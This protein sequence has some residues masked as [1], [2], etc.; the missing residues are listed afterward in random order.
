MKKFSL[1]TLCMMF[2]SAMYAQPRNTQHPRGYDQGHVTNEMHQNSAYNTPA[3]Y[4]VKGSWDAYVTGSFIYWQ[5]ME[6]GFEL[7]FIDINPHPS[8]IGF[9]STDNVRFNDADYKPGFKVGVG[10]NSD[11]DDWNVYLEYIR[12]NMSDSQSQSAPTGAGNILTVAFWFNQ[13][14]TGN[15]AVGDGTSVSSI[16]AKWKLDLN[17]FD[18]EVARRYYL[19]KKLTFRPHVGIRGGWNDQHFNVTGNFVTVGDEARTSRNKS[20]SW[21]F[22][23]RAG[24]D[25]NWLLGS[26]FRAI[27]DLAASL[28]YTRFN[29]TNVEDSIDP[30]VIQSTSFGTAKAKIKAL[31][32][33]SEFALGFG[34][35]TYFA[36]QSWHFDL[37]AL[38][39]FHIFWSQNVMKSFLTFTKP[40]DLT[41]HG[42]TVTAR[43]DF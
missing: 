31:Q 1:F 9:A 40:D 29:I 4:D 12:L 38:Y 26:G 41:I 6:K 24:L 30:T 23:A 27:G 43:F 20:D 16:N 35:G 8:G 19:G 28:V 22:G 36:N 10:M 5:A 2:T 34:W 39:E 7:A 3:R 11:Y 32:P 14:N 42:L 17:I 15:V 21:F 37:A 18:F 33:N 25:T 13:D